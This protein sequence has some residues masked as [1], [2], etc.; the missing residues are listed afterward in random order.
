MSPLTLPIRSS[1]SPF[2]HP[3]VL[4][5]LPPTLPLFLG[6]LTPNTQVQ[7]LESVAL[8]G[9]I[10]RLIC[11]VV[12]KIKSNAWNRLNSQYLFEKT[13]QYCKF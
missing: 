10:L 11:I 13:V 2:L 3:S 9:Q 6:T 7:T 5:S 12:S 4:L 1:F 8:Q